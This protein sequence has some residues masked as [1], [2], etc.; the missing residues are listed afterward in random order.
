[1][2]SIQHLSVC[3]NTV[4]RAHR[5]DEGRLQRILVENLPNLTGKRGLEAIMSVK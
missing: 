3:S 2:I 4:G 1:M 5:I